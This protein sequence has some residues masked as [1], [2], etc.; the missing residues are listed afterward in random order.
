M[1]LPDS[2]KTSEAFLLMRSLLKEEAKDSPGEEE[3]VLV[4]GLELGL[5]LMLGERCKGRIGVSF[6]GEGFGLISTMRGIFGFLSVGTL[7]G[8]SGL[9]KGSVTKYWVCKLVE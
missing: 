6:V 5:G 8:D 9:S 3:L 1:D 4:K 7:K 2:S